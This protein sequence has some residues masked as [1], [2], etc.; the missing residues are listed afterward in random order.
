MVKSHIIT[1]QRFCRKKEI[2]SFQ[3][4]KTK[5]EFFPL[6]NLI[7]KYTYF[8]FLREF[9]FRSFTNILSI[10]LGYLNLWQILVSPNSKTY[11]S[12]PRETGHVQRVKWEGKPKTSLAIQW[13][14]RTTVSVLETVFEG[15]PYTLHIKFR[16]LDCK[17]K[18]RI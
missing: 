11:P 17:K 10:K 4:S 9:K 18:R 12:D 8:F 1:V 3:K 6:E 16:L 13:I 14:C 15:R 7:K 5:M 2:A